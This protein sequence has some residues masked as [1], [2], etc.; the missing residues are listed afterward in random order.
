MRG[1]RKQGPY[2]PPWSDSTAELTPDCRYDPKRL[3]PL[4]SEAS[5]WTTYSSATMPANIVRDE[6]ADYPKPEDENYGQLVRCQRD[7]NIGVRT[8]LG[9][10]DDWNHSAASPSESIAY[11]SPTSLGTLSLP[12]CQVCCSSHISMSSPSN[13]TSINPPS[14]FPPVRRKP[15]Q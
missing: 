3:K 14:A 6:F 13:V 15:Y 11:S 10:H 12:M 8:R 5:I 2:C 9:S 4:F 7:N 1:Y